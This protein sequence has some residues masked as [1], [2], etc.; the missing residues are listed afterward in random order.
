MYAGN[1]QVVREQFL[2]NAPL[3]V[4]AKDA[5][6]RPAAG[7]TV[8]WAITQGT[9][10]LNAPTLTTDA[11]GLASTNFLATSLQPLQSFQSETITATSNF[12][13]VNFFITTV[14]EIT[15]PSVQLINPTLDN[16]SIT[17]ASGS[18]VPGGVV[19]RVIAQSGIQSGAPIPNIGVRIVDALDPTISAQAVCNAPLGTVLTDSTGTATCDLVISGPTGTEPLRAYCGHARMYADA[20][21]L[22]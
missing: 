1:G 7:V 4:Q 5:A 21:G 22:V 20:P 14:P 13:G 8:S 12:G 19:V 17:A 9:G 16:R 10:T 11:N 15:P 18:T 6:G 3:V 2:S